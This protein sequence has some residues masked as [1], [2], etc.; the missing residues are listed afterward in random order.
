VLRER[1]GSPHAFLAHGADALAFALLLSPS[2]WEHHYV[3]ALPLA[4]VA[5]AS[6][7][8]DRP[9]LLALGLFATLAMPTFDLYP[10]A[11]Q[12][13]AGLCLL[14]GLTGPGRTRDW[15]AGAAQAPPS[16]R[17]ER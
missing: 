14:L 4:L 9:G 12:R 3:M 5:C 13:L 7:G 10:L 1:R 16:E 6:R 15:L 8:G 2:V 17:R 11:Y